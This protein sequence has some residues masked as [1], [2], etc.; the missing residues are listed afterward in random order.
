MQKAGSKRRG[1]EGGMRDAGGWQCAS[2]STYLNLRILFVC[3]VVAVSACQ[4]S[5]NDSNRLRLNGVIEATQAT[6]VAEVEGRVVEIAADEGDAVQAGQTLVRLDDIALQVQV[7][8]AQAAVHAA[9]ANLAL[10]KA[11]VRSEEVAAAQATLLQAQAERD[12]AAQAYQDADVILHNPQQLLAQIDSART[13]AKLASENVAVAQAKLAEARWWREFYDD[14]KGQRKSLDKRI[15]IAQGELD[16]AQAQWDGATAQ[17]KAL[18]AIRL[19]PVTLRAQVNSAQSAYSMTVSSITVA[20]TELA[21]LKAGPS[22]EEIALAE[23][24]LHQAQAQLKLA[25]AYASR[26]VV[27]APLTGVV[28]SRSAH[29]GETVQ[30]GAALMSVADLDQVTLVVYVPQTQLPHVQLGTPVQVYVDAYPGQMFEGRIVFIAGQAQFTARDTQERQE[31]ANVVFAVKVRLPNADHRL[32]AG[33]A[34]D[35]VIERQ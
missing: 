25:Q 10:V 17:V 9:E 18:E 6:V 5:E 7:K 1:A 3:I 30:P 19:A 11:G 27:Q 24:Q 31:R 15:A 26:A 32:R 35:A 33:M 4:S 16:A 14:D 21:E 22:P 23:A 2:R 29:V 12:G 20:E 8:Q 28:L 13:S 34:A